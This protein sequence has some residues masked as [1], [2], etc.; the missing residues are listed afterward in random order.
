MSKFEAIFDDRTLIA[1]TTAAD[2]AA[3]P[4]VGLLFVIV[5]L[6]DGSIEVFFA[7]DEYEYLGETKPGSWTTTENFNSIRADLPE[8]SLILNPLR[9]ISVKR[10]QAKDKIDSEIVLRAF[11]EVVIDEFNILR[12]E[13]GLAARSLSQLVTAIKSKINE[14]A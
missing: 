6:D 5:Q 7:L 14:S 4:D 8:L 10:Q 2:F 13:H 1:G 9:H 11:A 3:L 12:A